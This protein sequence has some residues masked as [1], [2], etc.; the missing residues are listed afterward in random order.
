MIIVTGKT[1]E[2]RDML[3]RM[4]GRF[5]SARNR[6]EFPPLRLA[7]MATLRS[8]VGLI[9]GDD[10]PSSALDD[11]IDT[12]INSI[13]NKPDKSQP[14]TGNRTTAIYGDDQQYFNYFKDKNPYAFF[15]FSSLMECVKYIEKI[16]SDMRANGWNNNEDDFTKTRNMDHAIDLVR[17]GWP[18]GIERAEEIAR[19]MDIDAP[20]QRKR[21]Y[22]VAGG[23]VSVGRLIAGNPLHMVER[24]KQPGRKIVTLFVENSVSAAVS[25]DSLTLRA[26]VIAAM[27]DILERQGYSCQ[28][29]ALD[30]S[31][32]VGKPG[33]HIA[34]TIKQAG[35]KLN[36]NDTAFALGHPSFLRRLCF[37]LVASSN[38]CRGFWMTQ[39]NATVS[40]NDNYKPARNEF[41]LKAPSSSITDLNTMIEYVKP[42]GLEIK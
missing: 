34:V 10:K 24:S 25:A 31:L 41:Y 22:S 36:L 20:Q 35:E 40:F 38:E 19:T 23:S 33:A 5:N 42:E 13:G 2:H 29:V 7:D 26:S 18:E 39:G 14:I 15:G 16:P 3:K 17:N 8:T 6:W 12:L 4:G 21:S 37:A 1:F 11:A 30:T 27:V 28:I 9:V 32:H